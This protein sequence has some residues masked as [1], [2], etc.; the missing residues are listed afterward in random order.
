[1]QQFGV[2]YKHWQNEHRISILLRICIGL[3][4]ATASTALKISTKMLSLCV[5]SAN[6]Q[7]QRCQKNPKDTEQTRAG[8]TLVTFDLVGPTI[9]ATN[10]LFRLSFHP[11]NFCHQHQPPTIS[12]F[13]AFLLGRQRAM[14]SCP[15]LIS[16]SHFGGGSAWEG[17]YSVL[18]FTRG[19]ATNV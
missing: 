3:A 10:P 11:C 1:M 5:R 7:S 2:E 8:L 17:E 12:L 16:L 14:D 9:Q 15:K 18:W 13:V 4:Q 19:C 6:R